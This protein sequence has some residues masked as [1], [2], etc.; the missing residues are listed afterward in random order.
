MDLSD[1]LVENAFFA[2]FKKP[3][4]DRNGLPPVLLGFSFKFGLTFRTGDADFSLSARHPQ[5]LPTV[6]TGEMF[7]VFVLRMALLLLVKP[8]ARAVPN[9]QEFGVFRIAPHMVA[10]ENAE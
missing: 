7:I 6:G 5:L 10:G 2:S 4:A 1:L 9:L 3:A 8:T